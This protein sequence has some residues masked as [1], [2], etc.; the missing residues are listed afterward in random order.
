MGVIIPDGYGQMNM[1]WS[2]AGDPEFMYCT[3]GVFDTAPGDP[4]SAVAGRMGTA[5]DACTL[6]TAANM[7]TGWSAGTLIATVQTPTGPLTFETGTAVAGTAVATTLPNNCAVLVRKFT[8]LGGRRNR[9][10]MYLPPAYLP[11]ANVNQVGT[12]DPAVVTTIQGHMASLEAQLVAVDLA[13]VVLH[14]NGGTPA[15]ITQLTVQPKLATQR[16][17]MRR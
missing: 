15:F 11:E 5:W 7:S 12:I 10:R 16:T 4:P 8:N 17:R 2:V 3:L 1:R 6:T 9:G 14:S 13:M